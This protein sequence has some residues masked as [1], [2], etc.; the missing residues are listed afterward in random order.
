MLSV[1]EVDN[2]IMF[3]N[4]MISWQQVDRWMH[5]L[6]RIHHY[7]LVNQFHLLEMLVELL[8]LQS[9]MDP[10]LVPPLAGP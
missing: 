2:L 7:V 6:P 4:S 9:Q 10:F 1:R 5:N 3:I 8:E